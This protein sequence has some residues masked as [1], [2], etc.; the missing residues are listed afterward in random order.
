MNS[1]PWR[2]N[3][4]QNPKLSYEHSLSG[5]PSQSRRETGIPSNSR[6]NPI[7]KDRIPEKK[8]VDTKEDRAPVSCYGCGAPGII[9]SRCHTC[10]PVRQ[11]DDALSS[12][13]NQSNFYSFSSESNLISIIQISIC[14]TEAA[15]CADTG[16]THSVAGEKL[17]HLLT[18]KGLNF[19]EK[20]MQMTLADG[21]TQTTEIL[22]TSVDISI[23]GKVIPTE[24]LILKNARGNRT[25]LGIDFLTAAGIVLDLQRKQWYFTETSHRKYNFVKAPPNINAL[26]TVDPEPHLCQLRK[27]EGTHLSLPQRE[28][29][30][31]LLEKYEECFQPGGE[32]TPFIEH[33]INTRNHLPVAVP[34]Y[35]MN[36]SKKEILKQEIDRL[37]SEGIIE[38]CESP[39]ASPVVLIPKPNG[40][41]RLSIDYRKL[42]EITVA[43]TYPLPRMDDLLHQAKLTPFMSTLDLR[44]GYHQVKVHVEDQDKTAFVCPFGTYRFLRM[45]YGL[46][47]APATFQRLMN[48]FCNGLEDILALPYLDD[49][50]VLSETFEKHMFDLKIIFERLLHFKLKANREKCHFA[51]SRVKYLR[52]W[53]TQKGIEVDPE[54][55][56]SILDI[57]PLK[58]SKNYN[59]FCKIV[60]GFEDIFKILRRFHQ[61]D[62]TKPYIIRTDASNYALGAVLLQGEGS[63]EH[64]IEYASRLLTPAERN[65]STTEREALAV[66]WALKKFRGYIEG[67]EITVASDHQ[68]LKWLLNLKSPTGRL[69]RWALEIQSFNLKVQY[70][71]GKANVVTD[72]LSRPVIQEEESFCE[73]NNITIADMPTR[74]CKDMREAQLK[75]DNLKK[76]IDSFESPLKTEEYA[77]WTERGF[78]M[79][80]GVLYRCVPNADSAEAQL[81]IPTAERELIMERHHNDPMA[82]HYGEEGTFQK[83]TRRYYWTG[84]RKYL[85][86]YITKCPECARFKATNQKPAGL[87]RTPVY[88]Q[89]FEVIAIDLFGPLPQ[90]DTGKQWIFI[91]EDCATKWVELFALSQASARQCAT[92]L[93]EEVFMRHGIPRRIISDN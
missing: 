74:S 38:E 39:Y 11:K 1:S 56:A 20:T 86:D 57:P 34:P 76:I 48:R 17:Y 77:N 75:D 69:A 45:P 90:T 32:P 59:L 14:N 82:G 49:I 72:M 79:N 54:K 41:F 63:D 40:T 73:E 47:N 53:I 42:N 52:F 30:N 22:T 80:Q 89:R 26:L 4:T 10:N 43:D 61:A 3:Y 93:I 87:L 64:P 67:T 92:T 65:Y 88:S 51:S 58:T 55:V 6:R 46:R 70:I 83:I 18:Q 37:L 81:V 62:G 27:N 16:A 66:V 36:P 5:F 13:L 91:V 25:L 8:I 21:R 24:L 31:S 60:R 7:S 9:R 84:M 78:L 29:I 15:V 50:I 2:S 85:S 44:A 28:E 33:R 68:P 19:E 23:Q 71:P 12:S 35:R